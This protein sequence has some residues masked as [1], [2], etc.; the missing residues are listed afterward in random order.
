MTEQYSNRKM[1][2]QYIN[3][4]WLNT[5]AIKKCL[6][7]VEKMVEFSVGKMAEFSVAKMTDKITKWLSKMDEFTLPE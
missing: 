6:S 7:I 1:T 2:E 4:E 5:I 3:K